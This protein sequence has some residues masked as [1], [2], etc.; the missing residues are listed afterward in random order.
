MSTITDTLSGHFHY[1]A[2]EPAFAD[3][4]PDAPVVPGT[5]IINSFV[6]VIREL[7]PTSTLSISKFRFKSFVTPAT[8]AYSIEPKPYGFACTL[9]AEGKKV[10]TGRVLI[11]NEGNQ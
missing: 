3:H 11:N 8:Y 9:F 5:L 7:L 4:F 10:V 6:G 1:P 2:S